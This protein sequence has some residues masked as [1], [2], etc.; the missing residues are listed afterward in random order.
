[1]V[2][3]WLRI[4]HVGWWFGFWVPRKGG[5]GE[6]GELLLPCLGCVSILA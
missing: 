1:M 4:R 6:A 5:D 2:H 3:L